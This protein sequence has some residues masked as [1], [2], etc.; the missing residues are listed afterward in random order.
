VTCTWKTYGNQQTAFA[1][2]ANIYWHLTPMYNFCPFCGEL[3]HVVNY[4]P[5]VSNGT[6]IEIITDI[7]AAECGKETP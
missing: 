1:P 5:H 2:C 7:P 4:P 6:V 3:L